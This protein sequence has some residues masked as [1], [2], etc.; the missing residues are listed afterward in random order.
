MHGERLSW[1]SGLPTLSRGLELMCAI[2]TGPR[3][4]MPG[5]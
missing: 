1:H 2:F 5:L 3:E 4:V